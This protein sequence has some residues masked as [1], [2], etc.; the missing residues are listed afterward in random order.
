MLGK[1]ETLVKLRD[2]RKTRAGL[3]VGI[4]LAATVT[5][6]GVGMASASSI[7]VHT[8]ACSSAPNAMYAF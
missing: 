6:G 2:R 5:L 8:A 1:D 4:M 7:P 3:I